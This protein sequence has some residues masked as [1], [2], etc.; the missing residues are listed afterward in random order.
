MSDSDMD[1]SEQAKNKTPE[2]I[3]EMLQSD[4]D[5]GATQAALRAAAVTAP[6]DGTGGVMEPAGS[7][8]GNGS[9]LNHGSLAAT[10]VDGARSVTTADIASATTG[11]TSCCN[12]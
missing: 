2:E 8:A 3:E 11:S 9:G 5:E 7:G 1:Q 4:D 10:E 12:G 6:Q